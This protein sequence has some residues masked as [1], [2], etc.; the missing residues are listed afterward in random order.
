MNKNKGFTIIE[1]IVVIAIIAVLAS[2]VLV[3]VTQYINKGKNAAIKGNLSSAMV[4]AA[5][6]FDATPAGTGA[7]FLETTPV[8]N[9]KNAVEAPNVGS[10]VSTGDSTL[11]TNV[12]QWCICAEIIPTGTTV[13]CVDGS[14]AK[15]EITAENCDAVCTRGSAE[16]DGICKQP[17]E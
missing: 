1:L 17:V 6:Y 15:A 14:G 13:F 3:N 16:T 4:N 9:I 7:S 12:Q 8:T 10:N 11:A 5:T 2:I